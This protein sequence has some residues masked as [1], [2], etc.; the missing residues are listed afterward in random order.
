MS[1]DVILLGVIL[2]GI[3]LSAAYLVAEYHRWR[4]QEAAKASRS[5]RFRSLQA[6][7]LSRPNSAP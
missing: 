1:A 4:R 5:E 2:T 3:G 7:S 6:Q